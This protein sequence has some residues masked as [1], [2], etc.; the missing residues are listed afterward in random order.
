[1][2]FKTLFKIHSTGNSTQYSV[3]IY[4]ERKTLKENGCVYMYN[5]VVQ[6]KLYNLVNQLYVNKIFKN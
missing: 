3:I 6:H 5:F 4:V 1:M 2:H